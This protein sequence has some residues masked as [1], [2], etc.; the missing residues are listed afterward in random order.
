MNQDNIENI[1][2]ADDKEADKLIKSL[3]GSYGNPT[4]LG[5]KEKFELKLSE[6]NINQTQALDIM[7]IETRAL[8]GLLDGSGKRIDITALLKLSRFLE[9]SQ[10][11]VINLFLDSLIPASASE[12]EAIDKRKFIINNFDLPQLK[13]EGIIDSTT[14]FNLIEDK[15]LSYFGYDSIFDYRKD[16]LAP[17]YS[18]GKLHKDT[19]MSNYWVESAYQIFRKINNHYKYDRKA[20]I[21][22]FPTIRWYSL[23][24]EKGLLQV[25]RALYKMGITVIYQSKFKSLHLKGATFVVNGKPCIVLTN[26][27]GYY[28]TLWF[29]LIHELHHVLFDLEQIEINSFHISDN[30]DL[31]TTEHIENEANKFA[32]KYLFSEEKMEDVLPH[33]ENRY[34]I[35][36]YAKQNHIHPSIIYAFYAFDNGD[37]KKIWTKIINNKLMPDIN[38]C[39]N[40]LESNPWQKSINDIV[41]YNKEQIFNS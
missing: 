32:R 13:K 3:L 34:F 36:E 39:L 5:L 27:R 17:A 14:D 40:Q 25:I 30:S 29:S 38:L 41:K 6:L 20:L 26:Y 10:G 9:T 31:F 35:N 8:N 23:N 21:D 18:S 1:D 15:L 22:F 37:D 24:V 16:V 28:P 11:D 12:L 33:I 2:D 4:N 7:G 19:L